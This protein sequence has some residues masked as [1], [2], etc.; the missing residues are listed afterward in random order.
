M[1]VNERSK[2]LGS[3]LSL[4]WVSESQSGMSNLKRKEVREKMQ[5]RERGKRRGRGRVNDV[6]CS[7]NTFPCSSE[8]E[9]RG[10]PDASEEDPSEDGERKGERE[11]MRKE[12]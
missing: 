5:A 3:H 10:H 7:M 12:E 6:Q 1:S 4:L 11:N 8:R 9:E 2:S